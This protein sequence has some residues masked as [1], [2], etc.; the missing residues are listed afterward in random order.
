MT[1]F[2]VLLNGAEIATIVIGGF[3]L[4][5]RYMNRKHG[6]VGRTHGQ[7]VERQDPVLFAPSVSEA[8]QYGRYDKSQK[9]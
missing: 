7:R 3:I 8:I 1:D 6:S 9:E 5:V 4:I 2:L